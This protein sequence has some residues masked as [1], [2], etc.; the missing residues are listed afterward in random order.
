M[1]SDT[2]AG[3]VSCCRVQGGSCAGPSLTQLC[4]SPLTGQAA[5][6]S[7]HN[8]FS[9]LGKTLS[10]TVSWGREKTLTS[11][12]S[13][14]LPACLLQRAEDPEKTTQYLSTIGSST[15]DSTPT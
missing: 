14:C 2:Q 8:Y 4:S 13:D 9:T 12:A 11:G 15:I 10:I 6:L 5:S 7:S 3:L 1:S